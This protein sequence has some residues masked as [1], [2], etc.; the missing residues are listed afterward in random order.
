MFI[1]PRAGELVGGKLRAP[2]SGISVLEYSFLTYR[3][4]SRSQETIVKDK[5]KIN[6]K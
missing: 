1:L 2:V 6:K 3:S 5:A 4:A